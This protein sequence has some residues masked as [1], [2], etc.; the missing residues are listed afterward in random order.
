[1]SKKSIV[2]VFMIMIL[3]TF[4]LLLNIPMKA[5]SIS[6]DMSYYDMTTSITFTGIEVP[7]E[8][9]VE[10]SISYT[11][12]KSSGI[13]KFNYE[14]PRLFV[15]EGEIQILITTNRDFIVN[16]NTNLVF[17]F[18]M[19]NGFDFNFENARL[20]LGTNIDAPY[21]ITFNESSVFYDRLY[22]NQFENTNNLNGDTWTLNNNNYN[23]GTFNS[24]LILIKA[25]I[26]DSSLLQ[27][28]VLENITDNGY[29]SFINNNN[30]LQNEVN[31]LRNQ[32]IELNR[33]LNQLLQENANLTANNNELINEIN[34]LNNTIRYYQEQINQITAQGGYRFDNLFWSIASVPFGVLVS[35]FNVNVLGFNIASVITGT[36][37]ALL[38][39]WLIKKFM[40]K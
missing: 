3:T 9:E 6:N 24:I 16:E 40:G 15:S 33:R 2:G 22:D 12:N 27:L 19:A 21:G 11:I 13:W 20:Y 28:N 17:T 4:V 23:I 34:S 1:M 32:V 38:L 25:S 10:E 7:T 36:L 31:L 18:A 35:T 8:D 30:A 29:Y 14:V 5:E 26:N 37:T 39:I